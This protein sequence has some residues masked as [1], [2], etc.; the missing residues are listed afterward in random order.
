MIQNDGWKLYSTWDHSAALKDLYARRCRRQTEEMTAHA[1][2]GELLASR[3]LAQDTLLDVG[4][5]SGYFYHSLKKRGIPAEYWGLD[6]S[7]ELIEIGR[8]ILPQYGLPA[9][10]L[11]HMRLEDMRGEADHLVCI[12][13]L[14]YI[15]NYHRPLERLLLAARK[16]VI[17]RES[18]KHGTEYQYVRDVYLDEGIDLKVHVNHYDLDELMSFI[19]SYGFNVSNV[20]DRRTGGKPEN[21]IGYPHYW[22]FLVADRLP[23]GTQTS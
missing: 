8:Q 16:S 3:V 2:A 11:L 13:V 20:I 23:L 7:R 17:I 14:T 10:R 6:A 19:R 4:C 12:N 1:Q 5:G 22:A 15:D 9:E 18:I 21:V